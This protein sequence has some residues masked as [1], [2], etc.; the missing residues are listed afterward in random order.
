MYQK[1]HSFH[2]ISFHSMFP[3]AECLNVQCSYPIFYPHNNKN[4]FS[5]VFF[6][7]LSSD[8]VLTV[9]GHCFY[10]IFTAAETVLDFF[11]I[12]RT[13]PNRVSF[14]P[15]FYYFV[16]CFFSFVLTKR[17]I[18]VVNFISFTRYFCYSVVLL[19]GSIFFF[20]LMFAPFIGYIE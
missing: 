13:L 16:R 12:P 1:K 18:N 15:R 2:T 7:F 17:V 9:V 19:T 5:F 20:L 11:S 8:S 14:L 10:G 4:K 3:M 6:S